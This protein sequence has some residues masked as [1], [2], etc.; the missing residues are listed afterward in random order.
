MADSFGEALQVSTLHA[1]WVNTAQQCI[2]IHIPCLHLC[3]K[4]KIKCARGSSWLKISWLQGC[5]HTISVGWLQYWCCV[6]FS[7]LL[8]SRSHMGRLSFPTLNVNFSSCIW[9]EKQGSF[10]MWEKRKVVRSR[11]QQWVCISRWKTDSR[12]T[13]QWLNGT[14]YMI[15]YL[16]YK[17]KEITRGFM[18]NEPAIIWL[19]YMEL[20]VR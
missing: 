15:I 10:V 6:L 14:W 11:V 1:A 5:V 4:K 8:Y 12:D 17:Y 3:L 18:N 13:V 20:V 9:P 7:F 16:P 19:M 2:K